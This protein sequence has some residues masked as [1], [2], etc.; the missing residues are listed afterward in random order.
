MT[1]DKAFK[2]VVR[3]R[4]AKTGERYAAAR[5]TLIE[6][7]RD[8]DAAD[9]TLEA[10]TPAGYRM[11][12]GLH[13]ETATLANV[14]ANQGVVSGLT[15]EPLTEAAVL[16][17]GGGLG[18]GYI[19]WEF[20]G[21]GAPILTLGFRNQWQYPWIP[22]WTGKTL[23]RLGIEPDVHETGGANA[24]RAALDARLDAGLP[25]ITWIDL[26]SV[27]TWGL[28]QA[29]EGHFG[30][31]V[32]VLGRDADG[33]YLVDDRGRN[34][35]R[36]SPAVMAA[37]RGRVGSFKHRILALRT[38]PGPIPAERLRAAMRAGLEDQV[39]HLRS[40]SD[41]FS[42]PAW[43]KWAR[44]LTDA[45]NAKAWPRVFADGR[46][47]F[48]SLSA[49]HEHVDGRVGPW[50]GHLRELSAASLDEAAVA[51]DNPALGD[52][53]RA[54]RGVADRWE[55][56]ADAAVPADLDGAADAVAAVETLH[57]AVMTGEPGRSRVTAAAETA[58]AIRDRYADAFPL[59]RDRIAAILED[60]GDRL[61][62]IHQAEVEAVD[63][64]ARAIGR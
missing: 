56:L 41:S 47:L 53:A 63:L 48:G 58:W 60:L 13:P 57:D 43:R 38:T 35:F 61:G 19:L 10:A 28:P 40:P 50:G 18:A 36:V 16:G 9:A 4:M 51:L 29:M 2:R 45:R 21:H 15:G 11:R 5:R 6:G 37:A 31:V 59:P 23:D 42:L 20:K 49:I 32:V 30:L 24:A 1:T 27:G 39:D 34:P 46:G 44:L 62:A 26:Q 7:A 14:L 55:E 17:I 12:G 33:S 52:A 25:V 64:T 22:G 8:R 3:A 54:W